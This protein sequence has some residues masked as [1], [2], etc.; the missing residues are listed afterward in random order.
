MDVTFQYQ[1]HRAEKARLRKVINKTVQAVLSLAAVIFLLGGLALVIYGQAIGWTLIGI[2]ALPYMVLCWRK[3][4]LETLPPS[5][6]STSIADIL[7]P[8]V[9]SHL[10]KIPTPLDI[11]GVAG[12]TN[13]GLFFAVRFGITINFLQ[14]MASDPTQTSEKIWQSAESLRS[15][16]GAKE[17]TTG[18]LIYALVQGFENHQAILAHLHIELDDI[19]NG[20]QWQLHI[21]DLI[22]ASKHP[23]RTGGIARDLSF[24]YTPL[25]TRFGRNI[26]QQI[27]RGGLLN[28]ETSTH[29]TML[30]KMIQQFSSG[31]S[32]N[33]TLV[34][35][36]GV[37]KT[38]LV[39]AFAERLLDASSQVPKNLKFR[40]VIML[41][42][43]SLIAAA[44]GRGQTEGLVMDILGEAYAA[45]NVIICLDNAQLFLE[46]G[47]GSVDIANVLLPTLEAGRLRMIL[48]IDEQRFLEIS[49]R[50]SGVANALNRLSIPQ[51]DERESL[52][53]MQD[54]V[55]S[56]E[57]RR[58]VSYTYQS[59]KEAYRLGARYVYDVAMPGQALKLLESAAGYSENG[60]VTIN[61]VQQ[62]I[63]QTMDIKVSTASESDDREKLLNLESFIHKRMIG[64]TR[65][66]EV[67]S[68]ALRRAR[69]GVRNEGRP[70]GTFLFLGPTGVGKTELAKAL[71]DAYFGGEE[72]MIRLD[73]NEYVRNEDVSR[74]IADGATDSTSLTA[75]VMKQP[76]SVVLLDEIEKAHP[77]VLTTLLQLLDEGILRDINNREVSFRDA[78]II[79]TS[80]AGADRIREYIQRG[81]KLEQF[82]EQFV[83]ELIDTGQFRPEFLNRFDEIV[84]FTPLSKTD[85]MQVVRLMIAG[86]NKTLEQQKI[87]VQLDDNAIELLVERGYDPRLGARPMRRVIQK[88]IENTVAKL[89]LSGTV[90]PGTVITITREQLD[91]T[92]STM[93]QANDIAQSNQ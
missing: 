1:N 37:G 52:L 43:G 29:R 31:G 92:T 18:M 61:S 8:D 35:P 67:V 62:A 14:D 78:I 47:V 42:A 51:T 15:E 5:K 70:I 79:A 20:I 24:G 23:F 7:A 84:T 88:T 83:N 66:V 59:L 38:T 41:D 22:A 57:Y 72:R 13:D 64:Q 86:V 87:S 85:L 6:V 73:L 53:V 76:Y 2:A 77:N 91:Q 25:L 58:K 80:N 12:Q 27:G 89:L 34:G 71:A 39:E 65:A 32:Q 40:Q 50:N 82:E 46:E 4:E 74:L 36:T 68:D 56:Y 90:S 93:Q 55:L 45:K 19:K 44:A 54:S 49:R 3:G 33:V 75:Q 60:L 16:Y 30:E 81:Y 11:A 21:K 28:T 17:I 9:L 10:P 48:T 26:S 69:A 63:E